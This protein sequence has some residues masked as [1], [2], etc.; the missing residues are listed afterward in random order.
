MTK[1]FVRRSAAGLAGVALAASGL[2]FYGFA[3]TASADPSDVTVANAVFDPERVKVGESFTATWE[4]TVADGVEAS[5][6]I[7]LNLSDAQN[8]E[9]D[10]LTRSLPTGTTGTKSVSVTCTPKTDDNAQIH[11]SFVYEGTE[12]YQGNFGFDPDPVDPSSSPTPEPS[13]PT[14]EPSSPTTE[15]T[16]TTPPS[17][18]ATPSPSATPTVKAPKVE[19]KQGTFNPTRA[20]VVAGGKFTFTKQV[21]ISDG[22][23]TDDLVIKLS[24]YKN[25][26][27]E[28]TEDKL[29]AGTKPGTYEFVFNCQ[30]V[31]DGEQAQATYTISGDDIKT[32]TSQFGYGSLDTDDDSD[33]GN[34]KSDKGTSTKGGLADTGAP[35]LGVVL[36]GGVAA[37]T[38][39]GLMLRR[40]SK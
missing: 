29:A 3:G 35:A 5:T 33:K 24:D 28:P 34:G 12:I 39:G 27:C 37:A 21:V 31:K 10:P 19:V 16:T 8:L 18:T 36:A 38:A 6:P 2:A 15:P 23:L 22:P 13:S 32:I 26:K 14:T 9:C 40:R 30:F 25:L 11:Y 7:T 1:T 20:K 4:V 17:S